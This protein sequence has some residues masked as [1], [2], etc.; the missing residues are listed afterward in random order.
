MLLVDAVD[1]IVVRSGNHRQG[2]DPMEAAG[3]AGARA[4]L[5][6][7]R[8]G[9]SPGP[10]C[11]EAEVTV[12]LLSGLEKVP[13]GAERLQACGARCTEV[14]RGIRQI[15]NVLNETERAMKEDGDWQGTHR[16][17]QRDL[18]AVRL[19][20]ASEMTLGL[21][22]GAMALKVLE[23][24]ELTCEGRHAVAAS[25]GKQGEVEPEYHAVL[26]KQYQR[27]LAPLKECQIRAAD[28]TYKLGGVEKALRE[29]EEECAQPSMSDVC[30]YWE[31]L[32]REMG[33]VL[34]DYAVWPTFMLFSSVALYLSD[35]LPT[36]PM[37]KQPACALASGE[38]AEIEKA[39]D[40]R[41]SAARP[42]AAAHAA[43]DDGDG[44]HCVAASAPA[45]ADPDR[46]H[47]AAA[48]DDATACGSGA[49]R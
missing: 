35:L 49:E 41:P 7:S 43:H 34:M 5:G 26:E 9:V 2:R 18:Y 21:Q 37:E 20:W 6:D 12:A 42:A 38:Q 22:K 32:N 31:G 13:C 10:I 28:L 36:A 15:Q 25:S 40:P 1:L 24:T 14:M 11:S 48:P 45:G 8:R 16:G 44:P 27:M 19:K 23:L 39:D 29:V 33:M 3:K 4:G 17:S 47:P 30:H 46:Y